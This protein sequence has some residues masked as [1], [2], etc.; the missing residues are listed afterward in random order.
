[1]ATPQNA[2]PQLGSCSLIWLNA[3]STSSYQNECSMAMARLN[4][5]C[6][7]GAVEMGN[8]TAPTSLP[9]RWLVLWSVASAASRALHVE[10]KART[11]TPVNMVHVCV[12][13]DF[14]FDILSGDNYHVLRQRQE[15]NAHGRGVANR[16]GAPL[17]NE[18]PVRKFH[19]DALR[20]FDLSRT[21]RRS[22]QNIETSQ[23][24]V[25]RRR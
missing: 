2:M 13:K 25:K 3:L 18:K 5:C 16:V 4:S 24:D 15:P 8:C 21:M 20:Y 10:Y 22:L 19:T 12:V 6:R 11:T 1:M 17:E 9:F 7:A 23:S 14:I